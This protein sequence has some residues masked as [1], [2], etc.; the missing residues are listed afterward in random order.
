MIE[1][2]T[3]GMF[4]LYFYINLFNSLED[5]AI[6]ENEK[7]IKKII[8]MLLNETATTNKEENENRIENF[9]QEN[10]KER[11]RFVFLYFCILN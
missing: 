5:S 4:Q 1:N 7:L 8:Q 3:C 9:T 11:S 2:N 10:S 6:I